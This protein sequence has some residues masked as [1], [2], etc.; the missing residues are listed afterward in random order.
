ME[1]LQPYIEEVISVELAG[2]REYRGCEEQ[3]LTLVTLV[4]T[5]FQKKFKS[6]VAFIDLSAAY[7][8][9]WRDCLLYKF[10]KV[11]PCKKLFKLLV[12]ML[13]NRRFKACL[14]TNESNW[15]K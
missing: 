4:Q 15:R 6:N 2:F 11:I 10:A 14:G 3:V 5:G 12:G 7:Y 8:T 9:V 13:K 1:R